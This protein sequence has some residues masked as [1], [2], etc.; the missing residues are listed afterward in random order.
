MK[1]YFADIIP[2]IQRYSKRLDNLTLLTN[3][4]WVIIDDINNTKV[5]YIFRPNNDLLI[6]QNGRIEK[7]KWEYLD[8]TSLLIDKKDG[9]YL[10]KHG[11]FDEHILALKIDGT[12][13]HAFFVNETKNSRELNSLAGIIEFLNEKYL[14]PELKEPAEIFMSGRSQLTYKIK[15]G[16]LVLKG[17]SDT[18]N[19]LVISAVLNG[20]IA[21]DGKY[22]IGHMWYVIIKNGIVVDTTIF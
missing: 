15:E 10:F 4:H 19:N 5:V 2:K 3:Q 21:P 12:E 16:N 13:E 7:A 17:T 1:T 22:K 18:K 11:F 6:S 9:S 14:V 8:Q 20:K